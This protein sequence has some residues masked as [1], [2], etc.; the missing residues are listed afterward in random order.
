MKEL[1][2]HSDKNEESS[3]NKSNNKPNVGKVMKKETDKSSEKSKLK[4]KLAEARSQLKKARNDVGELRLQLKELQEDN[5]I[6]AYELEEANKKTKEEK[7]KESEVS[8]KIAGLEVDLTEVKLRLESISKPFDEVKSTVKSGRTVQRAELEKKRPGLV[9]EK[10]EHAVTEQKAVSKTKEVIDRGE[11]ELRQGQENNSESIPKTEIISTRDVTVEEVNKAIF[12]R[13]VDK[14]IFKKALSDFS[15]T[16]VSS[17]IDAARAMAG[18]RHKLAVKA[19]VA[20]LAVEQAALVRQ[21]CVK[22][23]AILEMQEGLDAVKEALRDSSPSVRLAAVWGLYQLS[24]AKSVYLLIDMFSDDDEEVRRRAVTCL[25]WLSQKK[26]GQE[27]NE[28]LCSHYVISS[29]IERLSDPAESIKK[30]ALVSLSEIKGE[31]VDESV[32]VDSKLRQNLIERWQ[33]WWKEEL[34]R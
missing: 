34:L 30:A 28:N 18:V 20:H 15:G 16:D 6:L 1:F 12:P 13:A 21:Q 25:G 19:I 29:L 8:S 33:K 23:L 17:R 32:L 26:S 2:N 4:V 9:K 24:G 14:I 31:K 7:E 5:K 27:V 3:S 11:V 10:D 22:A